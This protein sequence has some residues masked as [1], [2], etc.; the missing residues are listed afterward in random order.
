MAAEQGYL[1]GL[2]REYLITQITIKNDPFDS[3]LKEIKVYIYK[4][5]LIYQQKFNINDD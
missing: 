4:K 5:V 1:L 3:E 2:N